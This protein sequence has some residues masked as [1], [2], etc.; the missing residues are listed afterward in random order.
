MLV[1]ISFRSVSLLYSF[2]LLLSL[3]SQQR[4][5]LHTL[6][7]FLVPSIPQKPSNSHNY[8]QDRHSHNDYQQM[9]FWL[10]ADQFFQV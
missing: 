7:L 10:L 1:F 8:H 2:V 5:T 6:P 3:I 9:S 4:R